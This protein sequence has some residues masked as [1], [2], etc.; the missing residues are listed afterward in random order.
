MNE[1]EKFL[2][3]AQS[4]IGYIEGPADNQTKYQKA[5][6]AWCGAFVNWCAKQ[7]GIKIPNCTYTPAGATGFMDKNA[8]TLAEQ[9]DPQ[10]GDIVFFDFP[11]DALDR[12]SHV[13]IVISNNGNGTVTTIEGNTSP[14]KKGDQR[15]GGEVCQ[16]IRAYKKKN[17]GKV[18]P[19]LPVFIVGFGRPKFKEIVN[20]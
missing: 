14:D 4:E 11:G 8:W 18:Q 13:G 12:I 1:L 5:N 17:R 6:Q 16:K 20:E 2:D 19:S 9:A 3:V 15:N 7:A 10:P